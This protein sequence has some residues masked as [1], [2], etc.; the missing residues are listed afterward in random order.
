MTS[1][2]DA[3]PI[4]NGFGARLLEISTSLLMMIVW[5]SSLLFGAYILAFYGG[6]LNAGQIDAWNETLPRLHEAATPLASIGI[7]AHFAAGGVILLLGPLQLIGPVRRMAPSVHRWVGRV[8]V[9]AALAAG[10]G[11]LIFIAIRG[12]VGGPPM[13]I[14][15][16]LYGALMIL[17]AVQ[18]ARHAMAR[19]LNRHRAWAIRLFALAIGSWLYRMEYGFWAIVAGAAGHTENFQG[20]FDVI[21]AFF[22]YIPNLAV[23]EAFIRSRRPAASEASRL[24]S[25]GVLIAASGYVALA[26][27]FFTLHIWAPGAARFL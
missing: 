25:A 12:T 17:C 5:T 6:A 21:M 14:G 8:Y 20:W 24:V 2:T 19:D 18:T 11:G 1:S 7:G 10:I 4:S 23:A 15:F 26:T 16:G 3:Q 13:S 27:W 9:I 22:F